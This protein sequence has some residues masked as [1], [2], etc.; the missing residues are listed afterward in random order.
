[1]ITLSLIDSF[2]VPLL[3]YGVE[4]LRLRKSDYNTLDAA[5]SAAFSKIFAS[6][7]KSMIRSCQHYCAKLPFDFKIDVKCLK[8]YFKLSQLS[9]NNLVRVLFLVSGQAEFNSLLKKHKLDVKGSPGAWERSIWQS[10]SHEI[11]V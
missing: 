5:Y 2:C 11:L 8:F 9:S 7:D 3:S 4:A 1:M 10:F 6:Y